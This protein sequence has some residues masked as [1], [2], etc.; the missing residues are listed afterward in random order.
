IDARGMVMATQSGFNVG[1]RGELRIGDSLGTH[2]G[3]GA[4]IIADVGA[5]ALVRLAWGTVPGLPMAATVEVGNFPASHRDTA[6]RLVYDIAR[7][8][9]NGF[10]IGARIGY[11]ARTQQIGGVT[12]G[13]N[14][15]L[16]F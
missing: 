5:S 6:V 1:G 11:Q 14:T 15:S 3:L 7:P 13:L 4:E 9:P 12:L 8:F 16:D 2:L 10:R